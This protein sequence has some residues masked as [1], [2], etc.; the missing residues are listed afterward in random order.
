MPLWALPQN[1]KKPS[2]QGPTHFHVLRILLHSSLKE[3]HSIG[4]VSLLK[5]TQPFFK[6]LRVVTQGILFLKLVTLEGR[7]VRGELRREFNSQ[8]SRA[9]RTVTKTGGDGEGILHIMK[10]IH[11]K[12][13]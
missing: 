4:Q 11:D 10:I 1:G 12:Q 8:G 5:S 2:E 9:G 3:Q 7:K 6:R 13:S